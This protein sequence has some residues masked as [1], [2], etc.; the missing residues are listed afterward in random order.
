[1]CPLFPNKEFTDRKTVA[2]FDG[3]IGR[4]LGSGEL[5]KMLGT[6]SAK[7]GKS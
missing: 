1:V 6:W 7:Y 2:N 3:Y 4:D 5:C